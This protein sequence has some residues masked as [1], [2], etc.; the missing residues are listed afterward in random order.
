MQTSTHTHT[1]KCVCTY[2]HRLWWKRVC[3]GHYSETQLVW[4]CLSLVLSLCPACLIFGVISL[5]A[6]VFVWAVLFTRVCQQPP[7]LRPCPLD[8]AECMC[9]SSLG[10]IEAFY[11]ESCMFERECADVGIRACVYCFLTWD[12]L[13][14]TLGQSAGHT[15]PLCIQSEF[16]LVLDDNQPNNVLRRDRKCDMA[17]VFVYLGQ[18]SM[19]CLE[20]LTNT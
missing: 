13:N 9:F 10:M 12:W 14:V 20:C 5:A 6:C 18:M 4:T 15:G 11:C 16:R 17:T 1:H 8:W 2:C 7:L 19:F 3:V